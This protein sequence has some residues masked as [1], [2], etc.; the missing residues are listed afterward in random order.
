[1]FALLSDDAAATVQTVTKSM[2]SLNGLN[3]QSA[4]LKQQQREY[5]N[6]IKTHTQ[7]AATLADLQRDHQIAEA[8]FSSA[9]AK[10]DTS[11]LDIYATYPLTQLLTQPGGTIVRDRLQSKILV[12][13]IILMFGLLSLAVT[14]GHMRKTLLKKVD[15]KNQTS[16]TSQT[17]ANNKV[18]NSSKQPD[19][20]SL[21]PTPVLS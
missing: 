12:L 21:M 11:R 16:N 17:Q 14:L 7:D 19:L 18:K 13:A 9:L 10:L 4:A 6:R 1:M 8:I 5:Q 15:E 3:A 2:A 20:V